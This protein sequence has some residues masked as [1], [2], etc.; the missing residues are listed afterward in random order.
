VNDDIEDMYF[1]W[2]L[3]CLDPDGV[4]EG[5]VYVCSLL[6]NCA[7]LRRVGHDDNRA[8]NGENLRLEFL[9]QEDPGFDDQEI[10]DFLAYGC[11]WLEMLIAFCRQL[12]FMYEGSTQSRFLELVG[13]MGLDP[14]TRFNPHRSRRL[15]E[16]DQGYVN[17]ATS[18]ID[19]NRF[20]RNGHG[21]LFP[22]REPHVLDQREVELWEQQSAYFN[23]RLEGVL[24]T[25]TN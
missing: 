25:S 18:K 17:I 7:F 19:N 11:T 9:D 8:S 12:S 20:D 10:D 14:L 22:L 21:G 23:E 15:E 3:T 16:Y 1:E 4:K 6:Q 2:L 24:W 13:N 5:V